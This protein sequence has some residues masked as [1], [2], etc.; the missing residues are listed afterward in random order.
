MHLN[1]KMNKVWLKDR[2]SSTHNHQAQANKFDYAHS[3]RCARQVT[4]EKQKKKNTNQTKTT[5]GI[6]K[7]FIWNT[8]LYFWAMI[9]WRYASFLLFWSSFG[10][11]MLSWL[12]S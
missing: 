11:P 7:I 10:G 9:L 6:G 8:C 3:P 5:S 2:N 4:G 12:K 1:S